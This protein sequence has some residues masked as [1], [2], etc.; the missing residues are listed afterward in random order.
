MIG[1]AALALVFLGAVL[2]VS[3]AVLRYGTGQALDQ[4]SAR[5]QADL[6]L[7]GDRLVGQLQRYRDLA[8]LMAAHPQ[9]AEV[10]ARGPTEADAQLLQEVADRSAALDVSVLDRDGRRLVGAL[11]GRQ[12]QLGSAAFVGRGLQGALGWGHGPSLPRTAR[13]YF[14]AA[15]I[16]GPDGRVTGAL[17]VSTDLNGIDYSWRGAN[18]AVIFTD[19]AGEVWVSNRS[20]LVF[21]RRPEGELGLAPPDTAPGDHSVDMVAG[22]EIWTLDWGPYLPREAMHLVK[23]LPVIGMTAE[24]LLDVAPARRVAMTQAAAV[25]ALCLAFGALLYLA[26]ERRRT[27]ARANAELEARVA[28]RTS[29]LREIND[30]LRR[31]VAE[32]EE[33]QAALARAQDDLVQAGKLSALGQMSAGISHELNQPLMAI[34]SFAENAVQFMERG[35]PERAAENLGRISDMARRM[36]RI[37]QNLRAF[38]RQE[39]V[40][41]ERV[42]LGA[43][44][45]AAIELTRQHVEDAGV[46]LQY[47]PAEG[48]IW[49]RGGEVRLGQVFVNLITNAVDAMATS[50]VRHLRVLVSDGK[51]LTVNFR[52]TG[53]GIEMPDKVFD[54]FYTTKAGGATGGMGLGL[55]ISYGIVQS[56]GGQIK[57]V[58]MSPGALFTVTLEKADVEAEAA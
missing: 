4:L 32:R 19:S 1:R 24:V 29:A 43:V 13:A 41:P 52:D 26:T 2:A 20:E 30:T 17:V 48:P 56:F 55:S 14:H 23:P 15:P 34:R 25:G 11:P 47:D 33:A 31:E 51:Q 3:G 57:G 40:P 21:W 54:P 37:I 46:T 28:A 44:L 38:A 12:D 36:G 49:V 58:N 45:D 22:H 7:A 8:V 35:K 27:L 42:E 50:E 10:L 18:P 53:P 5:G 9:V 39:S 6:A 16:F